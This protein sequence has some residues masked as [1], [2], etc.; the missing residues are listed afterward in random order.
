MITRR[1]RHQKLS[2]ARMKAMLQVT[3]VSRAQRPFLQNRR[4]CYRL[5][6][7]TS[8]RLVRAIA[9]LMQ[10]SVRPTRIGAEDNLNRPQKCKERSQAVEIERNLRQRTSL[11]DCNDAVDARNLVEQSKGKKRKRG[12]QSVGVGSVLPEWVADGTNAA[13]WY[14]TDHSATSNAIDR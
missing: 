14:T 7:V 9:P 12:Q 11:K 3:A 1:A 8:G 4:M 13:P 6:Q 2:M 10:R 5:G